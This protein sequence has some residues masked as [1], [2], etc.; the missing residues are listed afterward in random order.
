MKTK[1]NPE[2]FPKQAYELA[3]KGLEDKQ[4]YATLGVGRDA[5]YNYI[6]KYPEF[7][8]ALKKGRILRIV[9]LVNALFESAIGYHAKEKNITTFPD[10]SVKTEEKIKFIKNDSAAMFLL[11]CWEPETFRDISTVVN[12]NIDMGK[13]T[14]KD[15]KELQEKRKELQKIIDKP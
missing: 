13:L 10:G 1:Y 8:K 4:I 7:D 9:P 3:K 2:T 12:Q 11:K 6:N 15:M 5:F 14:E